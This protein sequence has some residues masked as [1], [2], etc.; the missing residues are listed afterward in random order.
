MKALKRWWS[1]WLNP[2]QVGDVWEFVSSDPF[3]PYTLTNTVLTVTDTHV[4]Y[5]CYYSNI[6]TKRIQSESIG[7]FM[8]GSNLISEKQ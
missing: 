4:Q 1:R 7:W 5:E 6:G 2:V 3:N 8:L